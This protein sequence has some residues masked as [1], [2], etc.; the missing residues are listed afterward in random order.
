MMLL[1][2]ELRFSL[3]AKDL[4]RR[5]ADRDE[6]PALDPFPIV[7]FFK[8]VG[9]ATWLA[10]ELAADGDTLFGL[11]DLGFGCPELGSFSLS[12][13]AEVRLPLGMSIERDIGFSTVHRLSTWA[14][15][16]RRA[17][18]ILAAETLLRRASRAANDELPSPLEDEGGG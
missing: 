3:R 10:T 1:T 9:A 8:P 4:E 7:K 15:W 14:A 11:A 2:P 18:S 12:E 16:S 17:G 13:L 6:H 5:A